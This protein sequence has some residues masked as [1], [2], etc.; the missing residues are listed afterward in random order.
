MKKL[1]IYTFLVLFCFITQT[2]FAQN[3]SEFDAYLLPNHQILNAT[4]GDINNDGIPDAILVLK[5]KTEE[6]TTQQLPRP[7]LILVGQ[8]NKKYIVALRQDKVVLCKNC[9]GIANPKEPN[10]KVDY[11]QTTISKGQFSLEYY[12]GKKMKWSRV[13]VFRYDATLSKTNKKDTWLFYTDSM[14]RMEQLPNLDFTTKS[15]TKG[16]P[17]PTSPKIDFKDYDAKET[18]F[19]KK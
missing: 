12:G 1:L 9:N 18:W 10:A 2:I 7:V 15:L 4:K 14:D 8:K 16:P 17:K 13:M 3:N 5:H 19:I 6:T 11:N